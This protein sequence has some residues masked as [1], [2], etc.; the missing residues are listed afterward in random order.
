MQT[1]VAPLSLQMLVENALKHNIISKEKPLVVTI[2]CPDSEYVVVSNNLQRRETETTS[3]K[4]G[5][6]N[7]QQRYEYLT[8]KKVIIEVEE[9]RFSVSIPLLNL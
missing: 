5:L 4:L 1:S 6:K 9:N 3:S 7:I 8:N 2:S